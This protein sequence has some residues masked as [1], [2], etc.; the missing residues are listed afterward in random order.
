MDAPSKTSPLLWPT[1]L[2]SAALGCEA[3]AWAW[4]IRVSGGSDLTGLLWLAGAGLVALVASV[5]WMGWRLRRMRHALR[6]AQTT[7][8]KVTKHQHAMQRAEQ[9]AARA[10]QL[11]TTCLDVLDVGIEIYDERDRLLMF[12]Q[13]SSHMLTGFQRHDDI[14]KSF[15]TL[16]RANVAR[17]L[18]SAAIGHE[19]EWVQQRLRQRG[20]HTAPLLQQISSGQWIHTYEKYTT[21][22][23]LVC[24]HVDV[25]EQVLREQDLE[26]SNHRLARQSITDELTGLGNRRCFDQ[27]LETEWQRG[28]RMGT[29]VSLLMVDIDHFK[30]YNDRFGHPAG[31]EALRRI[32]K[33]LGACVRRAGELVARYGGEE[34]VLL[35]PGANEAHA[36]VTAQQCMHSLQQE[37]IDRGESAPA[38]FLTCS[39]GV[40]TVQPDAEREASALINAADVAMYRAKT[41]GRAR[42]EVADKADWE[43]GDDTPRTRPTPLT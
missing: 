7:A 33:A 13:R 10:R 21:D 5:V 22:G 43:I 35:L 11:L 14:G 19:E 3:I 29:P 4:V 8:L 18:I 24:T 42:F 26:A 36:L 34:F 16:V 20:K 17:G 27:T 38:E 31:D 15:E 32:A 37:A 40:A 30:R 28:A 39:I 12:N 41:N 9:E 6:R 1:V 2:A 25:T 23:H